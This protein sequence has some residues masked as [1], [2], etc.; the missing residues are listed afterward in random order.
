MPNDR[1]EHLLNEIGQ[2]VVADAERPLADTLLYA[3]VD[4]N[5][6]SASIFE[7]RGDHI[8]YRD[9]DPDRLTYALLE[10][11]AVA[12]P[13]KRWEEIEYV[14]RGNAFQASFTY[15]EDVG[16]S[17]EDEEGNYKPFARRD[18]IVAKHFGDKPITYPPMPS[19]DDDLSFE[20]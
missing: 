8:L 17:D 1:T 2:L 10:L 5:F 4:T 18:S 6:V 3:Q 14:I 7:D 9:Y 12:E 20:L 19:D 15:P 16:P 11:W 13:G